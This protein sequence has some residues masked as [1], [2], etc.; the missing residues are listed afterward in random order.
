MCFVLDTQELLISKRS[1]AMKT[2]LL[3]Q[4]CVH[5]YVYLA[6]VYLIANIVTLN[7]SISDLILKQLKNLILH[8]FAI[9]Y[10]LQRKRVPRSRVPLYILP[11]SYVQ[12]TPFNHY[13]RCITVIIVIYSCTELTVTVVQLS[14]NKTVARGIYCRGTCKVRETIDNISR[15]FR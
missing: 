15:T 13:E 9:P 11:C 4:T 14:Y 10:S 8:L 3:L 2:S 1:N 6:C 5:M 12:M 7:A